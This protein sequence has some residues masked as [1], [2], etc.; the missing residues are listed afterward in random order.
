MKKSK[1]IF[2]F[3]AL[4]IVGVFSIFQH[5]LIVNAEK[6][7]VAFFKT[8]DKYYSGDEIDLT[9][10][11]AHYEY[12]V[13]T[14]MAYK[15]VVLKVNGQVYQTINVD[16]NNHIIT[17]PKLGDEIQ[18]WTVTTENYNPAYVF[19]GYDTYA[20][21][22]TNYY[23]K[24]KIKVL[25]DKDKIVDDETTKCGVYFS[26]QTEEN[27]RALNVA[28]KSDEL[29]FSDFATLGHLRI[30]ELPDGRYKISPPAR[31]TENGNTQ[32]DETKSINGVPYFLGMTFTASIKNA[33]SSE[34][35]IS[36]EGSTYDLLDEITGGVIEQGFVNDLLKLDTNYVPPVETEVKGEEEVVENPNTGK[37]N[38]LLLIIPI[39]LFIGAYQLIIKKKVFKFNK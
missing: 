36:T 28:L 22:S 1:K 18:T 39:A 17:L 4:M 2:I 31:T 15:K 23:P 19:W 21:I 29:I 24:P 25:C 37:F 32:L 26:L 10:V 6:H 35:H 34:L 11:D 8:Y 16:E 38:Y 12:E 5:A 20:E 9:T 27:I 3:I 14:T 30:T 13:R 7:T 33:T